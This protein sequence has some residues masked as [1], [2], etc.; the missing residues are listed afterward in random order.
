MRMHRKANLEE[1]LAAC[2]PVLTSADLTDRNMKRA[3]QVQEYFD[4][5]KI[6][7]NLNPVHLEIGC[8][9]GKFVLESAARH[10]EINFVAV[11]KISNVIIE[12]CE[13]LMQN[14]LPNV[15][16]LCCAAEVLPRYFPQGSVARIYLNF[17]NPLPKLGYAKQRL[18]HPKFLAEYATLLTDNGEIWQKTDN[19]A[20][21]EFSLESYKQA[22]F[23]ILE[24]TRDLKNHPFADNVITEHEQKFMDMG[25][26]I[27]RVVVKKGEGEKV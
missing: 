10:P 18:T 17:S 13:K 7:G 14:P 4:F 8:G 24:T 20:F 19:E 6:F 27:Y 1:R 3:A 5:Q 15:H 2:S 26:L 21:F 23:T 12:G 25:L 16:F 11:E 22:N 9:K